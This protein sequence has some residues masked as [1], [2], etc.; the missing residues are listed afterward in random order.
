MLFSS[1]S[2]FH[3]R[4]HSHTPTKQP[5]SYNKKLSYPRAMNGSV[6]SDQSSIA[7]QQ[8]VLG[9]ILEFD[10]TRPDLEVY[11]LTT[12]SFLSFETDLWQY[13][14]KETKIP[15]LR[16]P[17]WDPQSR[18]QGGSCFWLLFA[19]VGRQASLLLV[20]KFIPFLAFSLENKDA[21]SHGS[22]ISW[23]LGKEPVTDYKCGR[24]QHSWQMLF[25]SVPIDPGWG[26]STF[27]TGYPP[28]GVMQ[29]WKKKNL[30]VSQTRIWFLPIQND[31]DQWLKHCH[32]RRY[33]EF[34]HI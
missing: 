32:Y 3:I 5:P 23:T 4:K 9:I 29:P 30:F 20:F 12:I 16:K 7:F 34:T 22:F 2:H 33:V 24:L 26:D 27:Q 8:K 15:G 28:K 14:E 25:L 17:S 6:I 10:V 21:T 18:D 31:R 13:A 1:P 19:Q 11:A